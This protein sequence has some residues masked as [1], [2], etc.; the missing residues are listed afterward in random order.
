MEQN[1]ITTTFRLP[2]LNHKNIQ[3]TLAQAVL[4]LCHL[5]TVVVGCEVFRFPGS[6]NSYPDEK[7]IT[8]SHQEISH[9]ALEGTSNG[10][11]WRY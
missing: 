7:S 3:G 11:L 9:M 6:G 1:H 4:T 2:W 5:A 8:L 10:A